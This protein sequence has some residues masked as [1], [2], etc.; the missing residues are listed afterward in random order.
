DAAVNAIV[1]T[2]AAALLAITAVATLAAPL[3]IRLYTAVRLDPD[4]NASQHRS[5]STTLAYYFLP[6]IFFYGMAAIATALLNARR[7][8]FAAAWAP[9]VHHLVVIVMFLLA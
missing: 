7:H 5:V 1:T 6:Q 4:V 9:A 2:A 3:I 8:F